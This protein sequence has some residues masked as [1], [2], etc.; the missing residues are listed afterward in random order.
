MA[1][2]V[3]AR[4]AFQKN[5]TLLELSDKPH[6]TSKRLMIRMRA[7]S[8]PPYVVTLATLSMSLT[9]TT[10]PTVIVSP[11]ERTPA[12]KRA[13]AL[14]HRRQ[15]ILTLKYRASAPNLKVDAKQTSTARRS[16][17]E[18]SK[19]KFEKP[20]VSYASYHLQSADIDLWLKQSM[21]LGSDQQLD[22][23]HIPGEGLGIAQVGDQE[24]TVE[25]PHVAPLPVTSPENNRTGS[26]TYTTPRT[27]LQTINELR[28]GDFEDQH[29]Y[30]HYR[31]SDPFRTSFSS[32]SSSEF[33][34]WPLVNR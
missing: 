31:T 7:I 33:Q 24:R 15:N 32:S 29:D 25:R 5:D 10:P 20:D 12:S 2:E 6:D 22:H 8:A 14:D 9:T 27:L 16:G 30:R 28:L 13:I 1:L 17:S 18:K 34:N 4:N 19:R 11:A 21:P 3:F 26:Q 23:V